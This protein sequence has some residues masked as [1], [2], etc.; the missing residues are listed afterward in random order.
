M[1]RTKK[2]T[3]ERLRDMRTD[4]AHPLRVFLVRRGVKLEEAAPIFGWSI[5]KLKD[6]VGKDHYPSDE[7][8]AEIAST[9]GFA[10][11]TDLFPTHDEH[12]RPIGKHA[13]TARRPR[14]PHDVKKA[15]S[16]VKKEKKQ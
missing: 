11:V 7:D 4:V 8:L 6:V 15:A 12:G 9:L 13:H 3:L 1:D 2:K 10:R 14:G 16:L 5:R